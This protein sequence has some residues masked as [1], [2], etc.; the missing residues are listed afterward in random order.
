[1]SQEVLESKPS[2]PATKLYP[3]YRLVLLNDDKYT[4]DHVEACL[5]KHIPGMSSDKAHQIALQVQKDGAAVIWVGPREVAEMY[6]ENLKAEGLDVV[7]EPD[8]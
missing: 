7:L 2:E 4:F 6:Y 3:N 1:M 5:T 8:L